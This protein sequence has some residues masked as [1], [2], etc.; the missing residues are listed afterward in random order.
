MQDF[1]DKKPGIKGN[2]NL[3]PFGETFINPKIGFWVLQILLFKL[4]LV[5]Y[6]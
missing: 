5:S 4:K 2:F 3:N 6:I 1:K